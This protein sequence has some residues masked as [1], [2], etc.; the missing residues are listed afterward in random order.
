METM[1][2]PDFQVRTNAEQ[3][4]WTTF[5]RLSA[6]ASNICLSTAS[7]VSAAASAAGL[8]RLYTKLLDQVILRS[9]RMTAQDWLVAKCKDGGIPCPSSPSARKQ[10][11]KP[12]ETVVSSEV[13]T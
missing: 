1:I 7:R 13:V 9:K 12:V 3:R 4:T 6:A 11:R 2:D 10:R 8:L 5:L